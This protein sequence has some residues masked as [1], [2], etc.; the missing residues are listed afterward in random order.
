MTAPDSDLASYGASAPARSQIP[1]APC[2]YR[3]V[4]Q[5]LADRDARSRVLAEFR[6]RGGTPDTWRLRSTREAM[7]DALTRTEDAIELESRGRMT[8]ERL[9][10][11]GIRR[12]LECELWP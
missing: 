8:A 3:N 10:L 5:A 1:E 11:R 7:A 4:L 12:R 9:A 2:E 6:R